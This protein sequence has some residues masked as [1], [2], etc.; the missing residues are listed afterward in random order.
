[1]KKDEHYG[2]YVGIVVQNNDPSG[3]GRVKIYM[4]HLHDLYDSWYNIKIDKQF[5]FIGENIDSSLNPILEDLKAHLPWSECAAPLVG[6]N[7][8][9]RYNAY[10]KSGSVSDSNNWNQTVPQE[11]YEPGKYD[12]NKDGIGESPGRKYEIQFMRLKDGFSESNDNLP[13]GAKRPNKYCYNYTP[14][15]Y[16]NTAKGSFGVPSVG[17]HVW[18]FFRN[19]S[20]EC[21]VYFAAAFNKDAWN[22]VYDSGDKNSPSS[23]YPGAY[24]N[25]P[26][27]GDD[28]P[29]MP[30]AVTYRNKFVLNQKAGALEFVNTDKREGIKL[31][32]YS[33]SFKSFDNNTNTELATENDQKLVLKDQYLT[34][35]GHR[36]VLTERDLDYIV[37]GDAFRRI[38]KQDTAAHTSWREEARALADIKQLFEIQR[39]QYDEQNELG[40]IPGLNISE[41]QIQSG[42]FAPCP[43]CNDK[44]IRHP[45]AW[46]MSNRFSVVTPTRRKYSINESSLFSEEFISYNPREA[47][48]DYLPQSS[49]PG[50][51][52]GET[53]PACGG[54]GVS[55]SSMDGIWNTEP[56]KSTE[57]WKEQV[58]DV[59]RRLVEIERNLGDGG[60]EY[61]NIA[62]H[63][64]ETIGMVMNDF[65]NIRTDITG[66]MYPAEMKIGKQGVYT[67]YKPSPV[68][69]YVH[70]D[71]LPGGSYSLNI[72]NRWNVQV[73]AGGISMKSYGPVSIGGTIVNLAGEQVNIG[74]RNEVVID[75]GKRLEL[76][77]DILSIRQ[78]KREQ[79]LIDSSLG[80]SNNLVI[81][82]GCHIE[83]DLS[84]HHITAPT[85]IQETELTEVWGRAEHIEKLII[86]YID[87]GTPIPTCNNRKSPPTPVYSMLGPKVEQGWYCGTH[88]AQH[89]SLRGYK[90]S[91]NFKNIPL[92]LKPGNDDVREAAKDCQWK[93]RVRP[94]RTEK[95]RAEH[96]T[97][98][99]DSQPGWGSAQSD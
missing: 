7:S 99:C 92:H 28:D 42:E 77:A 1:M 79:V 50:K 91:H 67:N 56:L 22:G 70:V 68:V 63:R 53:C 39:T 80:V 65:G 37:R 9:G 47:V 57:A 51:I 97:H 26:K 71:D 73:G 55:P 76:V 93:E 29:V 31:T 59:Q 5:K 74:S 6:E 38:G 8:P 61:I 10:F 41:R 43:V 98:D 27:T 23:D 2:N 25:T 17:S 66:K 21:P 72:C 90:H 44:N 94:E 13:D 83:G 14:K 89:N 18:V 11:E 40:I 3:R 30:S 86:G 78:R 95:R 35:N 33:G 48:T 96:K 20:V 49:T 62:K 32:H 85:E 45:R 36:N 58:V 60:N 69:E 82:G 24:E 52:F 34:V 64:M 46:H 15:T 87:N 4:P 16:S 75:G 81:G 19:G 84:V 54:S 12:L 88:V